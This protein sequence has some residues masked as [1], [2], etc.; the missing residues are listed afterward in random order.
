VRTIWIAAVAAVIL[1]FVIFWMLP[2]GGR[3]LANALTAGLSHLLDADVTVDRFETNLIARIRIGGLRITD[4]RKAGGAS[5]ACRDLTIR[6]A[7]L[8][9]VRGRLRLDAVDADSLVVVAYPGLFAGAA[10]TA[11][12]ESPPPAS[13]RFT[14]DLRRIR[15][16]RGVLIYRDTL[17]VLD[18]AVDGLRIAADRKEDMHFRLDA[19]SLRFRSPGHIL[20][21]GPVTLSG[22]FGEETLTVDAFYAGFPGFEASAQGRAA[23]AGDQRLEAQLRISGEP[24][25]LYRTLRLP[26]PVPEGTIVAMI[27]AGGTL[28]APS[29]SAALTFPALRLDTLLFTDGRVRMGW[30]DGRIRLDTLSVNALGGRFTGRGYAVPEPPAF[31]FDADADSLSF[32][33]LWPILSGVSSPFRGR[34]NARLR[35]AG[36]GTSWTDWRLSVDGDTEDLFYQGSALD[37]VR[38]G[39]RLAGGA[40]SVLLTQGETRL[41]ADLDLRDERVTG[42]FSGMIPSLTVIG[43]L[44]GQPGLEGRLG[45]SG[46]VSGRLEDPVIAGEILAEAVR[47]RNFPLDRMTGGFRFGDGQFTVRDMKFEGNRT[48]KD[49][50]ALFDLEKL[51]AGFRYAGSAEG[52]V[53]A[54]SGDLEAVLESPEW[55]GLGFD[56]GRIRVR[57]VPGTLIL[58]TATLARDTVLLHASGRFGLRGDFAGGSLSQFS[59]PGHAEAIADTAGWKR[60][61][62]LAGSYRA[63]PGAI[64]ARLTAQ[65]F[66]IAPISG[67]L[68]EEVSPAGAADSAAWRFRG[69]CDAA[70]T[71]TGDPDLPLL[72]GGLILSDA[73]ATFRGSP[74]LDSARIEL[75]LSDRRVRLETLTGRAMGLRLALSG[76]AA[77]DPEEPGITIRGLIGDRSVLDLSGRI[78]AGQ[79]AGTAVLKDFDLGLLAGFVPA[80][81]TPS[82]SAHLEMDLSGT[83][84]DPLLDGTLC[85]TDLSAGPLP[86]ISAIRTDTL[87]IRFGDRWVQIDTVRFT[88]GRGS[89]TLSGGLTH[90]NRKLYDASLH[91][92]ILNVAAAEK[93]R[94]RVLV[95]DAG[96]RIRQDS[97]RREIA[98]DI[99][100]G[101]SRYI[102]R[103]DLKQILDQIRAPRRPPV[104][105]VPSEVWGLDI[106]VHDSPDMWIE[107]NLARIRMKPELRIG[108]TTERPSVSGRVTA[109][110]G[111][112]TYLDRRFTLTSAA[113][114]FTDPYRINPVIDMK[115]KAELRGYQTFS[116]TPYTVHLSVTG[117]AD[118]AVIRLT[119]EPALSEPDIVSL[120]TLGT[121][122]STPAGGE[123]ARRDV[124]LYEVLQDRAVLLSSQRLSGYAARRIGTLFGLEEVSIEGNLFRFGKSWGPQLLASKKIT[125]RMEVTY[126]STIGNLNEQSVRLDYR[127]S[128]VFSLEGQTDQKGRAG[129]DLKYRIRFK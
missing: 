118:Q 20:A 125:D 100:L 88:T 122:R 68:M 101:D 113:L 48:R 117:P 66:H 29:V 46:E 70:L 43:A 47:Y 33:A 116:G 63:V 6:Y 49:T 119:S 25:R 50:T 81:Y 22:R 18:V 92:R 112:L 73:A 21:A 1:G 67:W 14:L 83:A 55:D 127:L 84:D 99:R 44:S 58:D 17:Q 64:E 96:F 85:L 37:P 72:H 7:L 39:G 129:L 108:G 8:P 3:I 45:V 120:L 4:A 60:L 65:D 91:G 80:G 89:V 77:L 75:R 78:T 10:D 93:D 128:R 16:T 56:A 95:R 106:R 38:I 9:L 34:L 98:A 52:P 19:D 124:S 51:R 2:P 27:E 28:S 42:S 97:T 107:S 24:S 115:S 11:S 123:A 79:L 111:H 12:M 53:S 74:L 109:T 62:R 61:G 87:R 71:L 114:D 54:L 35:C 41:E 5:L 94:F 15:L 121:T 82:G 102:G 69:I 59:R 86:W 40:L 110:E 76:E 105:A 23:L 103:V 57:L 126:T 13:S 31:S 90:R 30:R 36:T 104:Q 26:G 32:G